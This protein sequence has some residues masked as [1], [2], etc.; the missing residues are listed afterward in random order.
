MPQGGI[1]QDLQETFQDEKQF[2]FN[3]LSAVFRF[4]SNP[5]TENRF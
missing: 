2:M 3:V 5:Q 4:V 1:K